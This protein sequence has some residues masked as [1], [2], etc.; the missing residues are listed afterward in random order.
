MSDVAVDPLQLEQS[1]SVRLRSCRLVFEILDDATIT[2]SLAVVA[3]LKR[4]SPDPVSLLIARYP[5]V[6][7]AY[8]VSEAI[9][10]YEGGT[11][12]PHFTLPTKQADQTA[13][14]TAFIKALG[15]FG[16]ET[17]E[18]LSVQGMKYV[19][20]ILAHAGIPRYCVGDFFHRLLIPQLRRGFGASA[21]ELL[22]VWRAR[23]TAF[24]GIDV[25]VKR[26]VLYGGSPAVDLVDRCIDLIA[27]KAGGSPA[28]PADLGLPRQ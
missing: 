23:Q 2:E 11:F 22:A 14:G 1:L 21:G 6:L 3:W 15:N 10:K 9:E 28:S 26:F 13:L 25:P 16:L 24:V 7:S 19:T 8:L 17:F 5:A 18:F 20:P 27:H 12:W 4:Q